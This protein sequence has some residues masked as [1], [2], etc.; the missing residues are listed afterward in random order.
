MASQICDPNRPPPHS[1]Y[2]I[3]LSQGSNL[4][5]SI[6]QKNPLSGVC[7]VYVLESPTGHLV[8]EIL[9]LCLTVV[10]MPTYRQ[11]RYSY[12]VP[13]DGVEYL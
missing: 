5:Q 11:Y 9:C 12:N 6:V 7:R 1:V 4:T 13:R 3:N 10:G 8:D 2:R